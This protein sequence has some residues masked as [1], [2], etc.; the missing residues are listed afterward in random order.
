MG[1]GAVIASSSLGYY[2]RCD[3]CGYTPNKLWY[4]YAGAFLQAHD[5]GWEFDGSHHTCE[6][7]QGKRA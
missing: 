2:L 5:W 6:T 4:T 3:Q 1:G 7:C